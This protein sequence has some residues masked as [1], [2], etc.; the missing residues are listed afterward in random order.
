MKD[1]WG[2]GIGAIIVRAPLCNHRC[3]PACEGREKK[4]KSSSL[5]QH[6][7]L[8]HDLISIKTSEELPIYNFSGNFK[9]NSNHDTVGKLQLPCHGNNNP[10]LHTLYSADIQ[11][12][13]RL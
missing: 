8:C 7:D 9:T 1:Y 11:G 4:T 13:S 5:C 6:E 12:V 3:E 2:G 10:R